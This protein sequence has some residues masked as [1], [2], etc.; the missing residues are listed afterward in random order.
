M[1]ITVNIKAPELSHA[2]LELAS[3]LA[4]GV[5]TK[6]ELAAPMGTPPEDKPKAAGRTTAKPE[7]RVESG[8][9][10]TV[11]MPT[12][13]ELRAAAQQKG[14]TPE[15]KQAIKALLDEFGSR[16]I[17]EVA[18]NKRSAFLSRLEAL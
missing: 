8:A 3:V 12:V 9:S 7:P 17:S 2:I 10:L 15:G 18:E 16:S 13:V 4:M 6:A 11:P 5:S 14:A 1:E